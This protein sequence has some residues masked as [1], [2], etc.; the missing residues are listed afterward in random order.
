MDVGHGPAKGE[1]SNALSAMSAANSI[2][3]ISGSTPTLS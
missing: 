1:R 3:V 2:S